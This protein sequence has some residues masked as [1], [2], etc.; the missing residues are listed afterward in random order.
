MLRRL[1]KEMTRD[2][3]DRATDRLH[4]AGIDTRAFLLLRPPHCQDEEAVR[5]VVLSLR[6]VFARRVR[7]ASIIPVRAGNGWIDRAA[8][9]GHFTPPSRGALEATLEAGL[10][11][12]PRGVV[13]LDLWDWSGGR[14][15]VCANARRARLEQMNLLQHG[16][17]PLECPACGEQESNGGS[18]LL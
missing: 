12:Q 2:D 11:L 14:C 9:R 7:H 15:A 1:N 6:H 3:F 8:R 4:R 17:P 18:S 13:T 10:T 16:L 5:W